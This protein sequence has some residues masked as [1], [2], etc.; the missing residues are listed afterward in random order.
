M[1]Y[2]LGGASCTTNVGTPMPLGAKRKGTV[3]LF[4]D[5]NGRTGR[6]WHTLLLS[7]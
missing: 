4:S 6:L 7:H 2:D 5:G 1:R 3:N